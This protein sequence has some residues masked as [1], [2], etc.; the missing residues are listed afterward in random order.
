MIVTKAQYIP[1][2]SIYPDKNKN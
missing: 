2:I 1:D